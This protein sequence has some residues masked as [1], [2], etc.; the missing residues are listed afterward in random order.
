MS[1]YKGMS[2]LAI[3]FFIFDLSHEDTLILLKKL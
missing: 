3:P 1:N 2:Y